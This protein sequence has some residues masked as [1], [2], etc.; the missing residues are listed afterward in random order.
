[1]QLLPLGQ[2]AVSDAELDDA[3]VTR[4]HRSRPQLAVG[5]VDL[6]DQQKF[7]H[8]V[9]LDAFLL[10]DILDVVQAVICSGGGGN[11][12]RG[13]QRLRAIQQRDVRGR[14][15]ASRERAASCFRLQLRTNELAT[16]V[17]VNLFLSDVAGQPDRQPQ[18]V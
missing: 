11:D 7:H 18:L 6:A 16:G 15:R 12:K 2:A 1:M 17:R 9:A 13:Q 3:V 14:R 8:G 4:R 5:L 10:L